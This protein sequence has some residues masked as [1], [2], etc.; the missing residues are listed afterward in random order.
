MVLGGPQGHQG[1]PVHD[2]GVSGEKEDEA[3]QEDLA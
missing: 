3:G 1:E 2:V